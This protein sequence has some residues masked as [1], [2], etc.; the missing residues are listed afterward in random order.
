VTEP[1]RRRRDTRTIQA[2]VAAL[3]LIYAILFIVLNAHRVKVSFVFFS[4]RTSLIF[5]ILLSLAVG[6]VL[7]A[8]GPRLYR[9]RQR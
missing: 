6:C 9:H 5:V 7:G 4:T 8:V 3:V 1:A 2:G